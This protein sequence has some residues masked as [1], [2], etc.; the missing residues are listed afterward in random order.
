MIEV[1][2]THLRLIIGGLIFATLVSLFFL[3][4]AIYIDRNSTAETLSNMQEDN[5]AATHSENAPAQE[6]DPRILVSDG[7]KKDRF[8][9]KYSYD[10]ATGVCQALVVNSWKGAASGQVIDCTPE[11][12]RL[13]PSTQENE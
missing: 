9:F 12:M 11:V 13:F 6:L 8:W 10:S 1:S 4:S 5:T 2:E 3:L 7:V